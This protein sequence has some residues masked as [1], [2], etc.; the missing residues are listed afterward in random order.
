MLG[1]PNA[2]LFPSAFVKFRQFSSRLTGH[3]PNLAPNVKLEDGYD[4]KKTIT[5][6]LENFVKDSKQL[7]LADRKPSN[8]Y[9][10]KHHSRGSHY[11]KGYSRSSHYDKHYS[12][13]KKHHS[14]DKDHVVKPTHGKRRDDHRR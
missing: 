2:G 12:R 14:H 9:H 13:D 8:T 3:L 7:A 10:G 5:R 1:L 11:D 6:M 4:V